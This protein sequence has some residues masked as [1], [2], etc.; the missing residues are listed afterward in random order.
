MSDQENKAELVA[1]YGDR[2]YHLKY[3]LLESY[4]SG[5]LANIKRLKDRLKNLEAMDAVEEVQVENNGIS[6][7]VNK[8]ENRVMLF[9]PGKPSEEV[10]S[11]LKRHGFRW[12]PRN[13]AWQAYIKQWNI[14]FAKSIV[15]G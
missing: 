1:K 14:D 9:F 15:Q 11:N 12:S 4:M 6:M 3:Y 13:M 5:F 8:A 7:E 2:E 10:R